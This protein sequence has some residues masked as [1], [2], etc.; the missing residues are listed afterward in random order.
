MAATRRPDAPETDLPPTTPTDR[1]PAPAGPPAQPP[2]GPPRIDQRGPCDCMRAVMATYLGV[3]YDRTPAISGLADAATFWAR[4]SAWLRA[5]GQTMAAYDFAPGHLRRWIAVVGRGH[6]APMHAVV[7]AGTEL[8]HDP[9]PEPDRLAR[10]QRGQVMC[11]IVV[12]P[13]DEREWSER[14]TREIAAAVSRG[15][16]LVWCLERLMDSQWGVGMYRLRGQQR[17]ADAMR[18]RLGA[19]P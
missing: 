3:P 17:E 7:M 14:I 5:R 15:S 6:L 8:Y 2:A 11:A 12:G 19:A 9:M 18:R 4:W 13:R 1:A 10:V 16:P